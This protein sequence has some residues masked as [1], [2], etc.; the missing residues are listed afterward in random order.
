MPHLAVNPCQSRCD[1]VRSGVR[2]GQRLFACVACASEWDRA[3]A[4][5]PAQADGSVSAAVTAERA[6]AARA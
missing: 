2:A 1:W 3:Q 6:D 5:T 4:W